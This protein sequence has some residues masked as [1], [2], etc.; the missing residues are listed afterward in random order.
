MN[1]SFAWALIR[2]V[3]G[4]SLAYGHGLPKL[5]RGVEGFATTVANLGFPAPHFFAWCA[6]LTELVG[7][8]LIAIGLFT[9]PMGALAAFTMAVALYQHR[10]DPF[11][12]LELPLIYFA[13][14]IGTALIGSG[15]FGLDARVRLPGIL[16]RLQG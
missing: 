14:F 2:V 3:A 1:H 10:A 4:L 8:V 13:I 12:S 9:R 11:R 5:Q 6:T 16:G 7:G 15:R